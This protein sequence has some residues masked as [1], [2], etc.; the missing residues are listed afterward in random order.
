MQECGAP[1]ARL[2]LQIRRLY[3][4]AMPPRSVEDEVCQIRN[5]SSQAK[6]SQASSSNGFW[7]AWNWLSLQ[8]GCRIGIPIS[9]N[10]LLEEGR[11]SRRCK[12]DS[13]YLSESMTLQ[14]QL[15]PA[16]T[17]CQCGSR[18][19]WHGKPVAEM[20]SIRLSKIH[21]N[22]AFVIT[23]FMSSGRS[24][25]QSCSQVI[26]CTGV[27]ADLGVLCTLPILESCHLCT[28]SSE[29]KY[30][31]TYFMGRC[32]AHQQQRLRA[33]GVKFCADSRRRW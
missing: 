11:Q 30:L 18:Y 4:K 26:R 6:T 12:P 1:Q 28:K 8:E 22:S 10:L 16:E 13:R 23:C 7:L 9:S 24:G 14:S 33:A 19:Q 29:L 25:T 15:K 2:N 21:S 31:C 17:Y 5:H 20:K 32:I 27:T 3:E